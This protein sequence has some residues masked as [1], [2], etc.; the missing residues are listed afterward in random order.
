M[1]TSLKRLRAAQRL[2]QQQ[3]ADRVGVERLA[4]RRWESGRE[5][6]PEGKLRVLAG[7]FGVSVAHLLGEWSEDVTGA[8][9]MEQLQ[10]SEDAEDDEITEHPYEVARR[11]LMAAAEIPGDVYPGLFRQFAAAI[12]DHER[13]RW[14]RC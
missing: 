4:V 5:P 2:T 8:W 6:T 10:A 13:R 7:L 12:P 9:T 11:A 3:V 14:R 1:A